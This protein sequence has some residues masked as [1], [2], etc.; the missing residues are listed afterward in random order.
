MHALRD[1]IG[2]EQEELV[3][4]WS[5]KGCAVVAGAERLIGGNRNQPEKLAQQSILGA[6][7]HGSMSGQ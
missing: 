1:A 6:G 3:F 4:S 2:L 5:A 7:L